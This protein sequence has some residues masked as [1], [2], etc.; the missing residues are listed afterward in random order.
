MQIEIG[1]GNGKTMCLGSFS[2][3]EGTCRDWALVYKGGVKIHIG[4]GDHFKPLS[5]S[6]YFPSLKKGHGIKTSPTEVE[7][8]MTWS[9]EEKVIPEAMRWFC[10]FKSVLLSSCSWA[11]GGSDVTPMETLLMPWMPLGAGLWVQHLQ[12]CDPL[13]GIL[14]KQLYPWAFPDT[15]KS[16][17]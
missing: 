16:C 10:S 1:L 14:R 5:W 9:Q 8:N 12:L 6:R 11:V 4:T 2:V 7:L 17:N 3:Q 15:T 13:F